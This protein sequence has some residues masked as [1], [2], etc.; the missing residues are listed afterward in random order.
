MKEIE[1]KDPKTGVSGE[2]EGDHPLKG[3]RSESRSSQGKEKDFDVG[4]VVGLEV[5]RVS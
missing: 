2:K 5:I 1:L 3:T 4:I